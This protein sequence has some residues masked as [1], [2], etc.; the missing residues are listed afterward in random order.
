MAMEILHKYAEDNNGDIIHISNA[1]I[2]IKYFCPGC[3]EE[4]IFKNGEIRQKHF[5][6]KSQT[7]VCS[8]GGGEGYLHETFKKMLFYKILENINKRKP[9]VITWKCNICNYGH[10][11]DLLL[12][13]KEIKI[14]YNLEGCRPDL[15]LFNEIG[16]VAFIIEIVDT[17][18]PENNVIEYC[19]KNNTILVIIKLK[20]LDDLDNID[21]IIKNTSNVLLFNRIQCPIFVKNTQQK[22]QKQYYITPKKGITKRGSLMDRIETAQKRKKT[23]RNFGKRRPRK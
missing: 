14:E 16:Q 2:G 17:H 19:I 11:Q 10:F 21:N 6:H 12:G 8:G 18:E 3:K 13:I 4:F 23:N 9:L 5:S 7:H 20:D 22:A 1:K 15:V